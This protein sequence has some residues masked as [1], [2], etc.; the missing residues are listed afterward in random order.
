[1]N[2]S[3]L[4]PSHGHD[5]SSH[6]R[7]LNSRHSSELGDTSPKIHKAESDRLFLNNIRPEQAREFLH[8][9]IGRSIA[10]HAPKSQTAHPSF[11]RIFPDANT[12]ASHIIDDV[13]QAASS[14]PEES[15]ST[16]AKPN[17]N[18]KD[19][20]TKIQDGFR[21]AKEALEDL[22]TLSQGFAPE[23]DEIEQKVNAFLQ[24]LEAPE[25]NVAP[26]TVTNDATNKTIATSEIAASQETYQTSSQASI[27]LE[28]RDGDIVTIDLSNSFSQQQSA[29]SLQNNSQQNSFSGYVYEAYSESQSSFSYTVSGELDDDELKAISQL[30]GDIGKTVGQFEKGNVNAALNIAKNIDRQ[31]EELSSF[32]FNVQT[33][34]QYRAI[35]L[36]QKTQV[37]TQETI[38]ASPPANTNENVDAIFSNN[39]S[40]HIYAAESANILDAASTVNSIFEKFYEQLSLINEKLDTFIRNENEGRDEHSERHEEEAHS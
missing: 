36:Y 5:V 39:I 12:T 30:V 19:L 13:S 40:N 1:M 35:D 29:A 23:F 15:A 22:G 26:G 6:D 7:K 3:S 14:L 20:I 24:F 21:Q 33:S 10:E 38:P 32:S 17:S 11:T 28:T 8:S 25:N 34:E 27:Q 4:K 31:S 18:L 9:H 37:S 16:P 2:V